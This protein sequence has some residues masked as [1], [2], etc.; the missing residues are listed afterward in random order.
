MLV[1]ARVIERVRNRRV[2]SMENRGRY[3]VSEKRIWMT[4]QV[5]E[6]MLIS[7]RMLERKTYMKLTTC[8][9]SGGRVEW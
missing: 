5:V 3:G 6:M 8:F 1:V 9:L 2:R 7:C 4:I